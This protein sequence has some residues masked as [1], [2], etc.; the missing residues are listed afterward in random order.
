[1]EAFYDE[2]SRVLVPG[3]DWG[4]NLDAFE[5]ILKGGWGTPAEGFC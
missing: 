4:R 2:I 5:E 1:L 3:H